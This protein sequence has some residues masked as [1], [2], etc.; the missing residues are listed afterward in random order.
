MIA[1]YAI[2]VIG[3]TPRDFGEMRPARYWAVA[4]AFNDTQRDR[5]AFEGDQTRLLAGTIV[6]LLHQRK[7][8]KLTDLWKWP[9]DKEEKIEKKLSGMS[10]DERKRQVAELMKKVNGK[11]G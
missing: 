9:W 5:L 11:N 8:K 2:G 6:N 4:R 10:A 1:G 3:L 7:V